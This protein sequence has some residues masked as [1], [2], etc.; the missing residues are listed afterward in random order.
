MSHRFQSF[1]ASLEKT[2]SMISAGTKCT[3]SS[4]IQF[5]EEQ[6]RTS[7]G[8]I[9]LS[10][11]SPESI[12]DAVTFAAKLNV[13]LAP[14]LGLARLVPIRALDGEVECALE[15]S[16]AG[17][18]DAFSRV[19]GMEVY[20]LM[21]AS[22]NSPLPWKGDV[23]NSTAE[24]PEWSARHSELTGAVCVI[25]LDSGDLLPT[26]LKMCE[27]YELARLA[28]VEANAITPEF[29]KYHALK[30]ALKTLIA[31]TGGQL[32]AL[33]QVARRIDMSLF[34]SHIE[35][36]QESPQTTQTEKHFQK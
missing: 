21:V 4:E 32:S 22:K 34:C 19:E 36:Q 23:M 13:S 8:A 28:G 33:Q 10:D 30:R 25:K 31:P 9:K 16:L 11:A 18:L 1:M 17:M 5:I 35:N 15:L 2:Y 12:F 27:V 14:H 29:A 3:P 26:T 7:E 20:R 6:I 24:I